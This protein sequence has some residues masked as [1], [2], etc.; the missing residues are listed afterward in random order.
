MELKGVTSIVVSQGSQ[1]GFRNM[2][3]E[4]KMDVIASLVQRARHL[5]AH[6]QP[7]A[8][9]HNT[10]QQ[11]LFLEHRE[12][13][14]KLLWPYFAPIQAQLGISFQETNKL[15]HPHSLRHFEG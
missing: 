6:A 8:A 4:S 7:K 14:L 1:S 12:I 13:H 11:R 2:F 10:F 9:T 3:S 15:V 5:R